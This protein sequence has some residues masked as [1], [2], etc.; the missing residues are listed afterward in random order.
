MS[1][2]KV[3]SWTGYASTKVAWPTERT[4]LMR[5]LWVVVSRMYIVWMYVQYCA[6]A[7]RQDTYLARARRAE[8]R[9]QDPDDL[10]VL[11]GEKRSPKKQSH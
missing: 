3:A 10:T 9:K 1:M 8:Q 11:Y 2:E 5:Q 7:K 4:R 6:R